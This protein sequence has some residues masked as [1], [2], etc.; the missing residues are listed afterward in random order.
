MTAVW[1][2]DI[3]HTEK[4]VLL[5][6]AD[7]A[8]DE[9]DCYPAISTITRKCGLS[10]RTVQ[11]VINLLESDGMVSRHF[12]SGRSTLYRVTPAN[13]APPQMSPPASSAPTPAQIAPPPP[14]STAQ[15]P[16]NVAP[17]TSK[18]PSIEPSKKHHSVEASEFDEVRQAYPKR[19]GGNNW[20]DAEK[21]YRKRISEGHTHAEIIAGIRRYAEFND[22]A[23]KTGTEYV[24]M[25]ST[26]LGPNKSFLEPW[27]APRAPPDTRQLSAVERVRLANGAK[28][29]ERVVSEQTRSGFGDL[30]ILGG[31]VRQSPNSGLRRLGS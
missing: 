18:K 24:K 23:G 30:D 16:A 7:N 11:S 14:Q 21:A 31:D 20:A 1:S 17:I 27:T 29:D 5:A 15:T 22:A 25:A 28:N 19:G 12:R 13:V 10:E 4:I 9:G 26:F 6:L 8:N 2:L 3:G